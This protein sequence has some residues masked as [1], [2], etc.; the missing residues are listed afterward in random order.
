MTN[1]C[2]L[3]S[4]VQAIIQAA[5]LSAVFMRSTVTRRRFITRQR[6]H[7]HIHICDR[8]RGM[9]IFHLLTLTGLVTNREATNKIW[10]EHCNEAG[11]SLDLIFL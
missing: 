4:P 8:K 1:C 7:V 9:T 10:L 5:L 11:Y 2:V 6:L 3:S